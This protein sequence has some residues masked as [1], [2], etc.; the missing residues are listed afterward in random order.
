MCHQSGLAMIFPFVVY[1]RMQAAH[2]NDGGFDKSILASENRGEVNY[3]Y[4]EN[5]Q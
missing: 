4:F 5:M 3:I 2:N 1:L